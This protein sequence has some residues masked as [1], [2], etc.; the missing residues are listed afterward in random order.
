MST[1]LDPFYNLIKN[2]EDLENEWR[3]PL[4]YTLQLPVKIYLNDFFTL[5]IIITCKI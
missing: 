4:D 5:L 2:I 3:K 1:S